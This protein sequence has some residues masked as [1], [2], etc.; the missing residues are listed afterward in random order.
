M[1]YQVS[2]W[3]PASLANYLLQPLGV[4]LVFYVGLIWTTTAFVYFAFVVCYRRLAQRFLVALPLLCAAAW[5]V[6]DLVRARLPTE[7]NYLMGNCWALFGYSQAS[8]EPLAQIASVTGVY[9]IAFLLVAVNA[10][11]AE[12]WL[13]RGS[14]TGAF[15]RTAA[16]L[17]MAVFIAASVYGFGAMSLRRAQA[18]GSEADSVSVAIVQGNINLRARWRRDLYGR[19]LEIYLRGTQRVLA[20]AKPAIVFWPEGAM[21]FFLDEE[22]AYQRLIGRVLREA[23]VELVAGAPR[24]GGTEDE[25]RYFNST[26]VVSPEGEVRAHYDKRLLV[27]FTEHFPLPGTDLLRRQF[28][29]ARVFTPG[30]PLPPLSTAAGAAGVVACNEAMYATIV[31][32]RV[33]EGAQYIFNPSNDSWIPHLQFAAGQFDFV[34]M[35]AIEQRRYV[36]RAS[37]NGF[38]GVVDPWGRVVVRTEP[39]T[40][41]VTVGRIAPR[42]ELTLYARVGDIFVALCAAAMAAGLLRRDRV[43]Q[44]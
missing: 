18:P 3:F 31:G 23:G 33:R 14:G 19:N 11:L 35:R 6:A 5:S 38:S 40:R 30:L 41:A 44:R 8:V 16:G 13:R 34:R 10:A 9:G 29:R 36:V 17:G 27:P 4:G 21:T 2:R 15:R 25:R 20:D 7:T 32:D 42:D 24:Q 39:F 22:P 1:G 26:F 12:I 28:G 37:T 43:P